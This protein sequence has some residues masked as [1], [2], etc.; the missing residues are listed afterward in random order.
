MG[1]YLSGMFETSKI[2]KT[3]DAAASNSNQNAAGANA[4]INNNSNVTPN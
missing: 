2:P 3:D 4:N 1:E